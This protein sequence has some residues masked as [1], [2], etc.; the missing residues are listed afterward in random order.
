MRRTAAAYRPTLHTCVPVIKMTNG[1]QKISICHGNEQAGPEYAI[2]E[3]GSLRAYGGNN[4]ISQ[5][6]RQEADARLM[7]ASQIKTEEKLCCS[8]ENLEIIPRLVIRL[9]LNQAN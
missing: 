1:L 8:N 7:A 6:L 2:E 9:L 4:I 5:S 3:R